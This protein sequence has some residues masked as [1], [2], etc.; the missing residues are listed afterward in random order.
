MAITVSITSGNQ[1]EG[2]RINAQVS[3]PLMGTLT[4]AQKVEKLNDMLRS[5]LAIMRSYDQGQSLGD[6]AAFTWIHTPKVQ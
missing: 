5:Q 1:I 6:A 2:M 4:D 3:D